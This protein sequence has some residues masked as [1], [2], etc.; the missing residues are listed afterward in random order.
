M[1]SLPVRQSHFTRGPAA[2]HLGASL[3]WLRDS[4]VGWEAVIVYTAMA[5]LF[6]RHTVAHLGSNCSCSELADSWQLTWPF[7]WFPY[8]LTHGLNPWYTHAL[9][10][11]PGFNV[12]GVTS[13]P[14]PAILFAPVTWLWGPIVA[15]NLAILAAM[16]LTAWATYQ[17][18]R[19]VS[20]DRAAALVAGAT[21]GFGTY[22][23]LQMGVGHIFMTLFV[24]P[25]L[26][27]FAALRYMDGAIGRRRVIV[28]LTV[29]LIIQLFTGQEVLVTMTLF[30]GV[31]LLLGYALGTREIRIGLRKLILPLVIGYGVTLVLSGD[32]LYWAARA[33]KYSIGIGNAWPTDL[34]SYVIPTTTTWVGGPQF[35]SVYGL[36]N[37]SAESVA[38]IGLPLIL[39]ALRWICTR[40]QRKLSR[41]LAAASVLS[42]LWTLGPALHVAGK[43]TMWLP[44]RLI[45]GLPVI[46]Q[47]L[48]S[49]TAVYTE[50]LAA[51]ML[52]LWLADRRRRPWLKW[53]AALVAALC[54]FPNFVDV[55]AA[56]DSPRGI[57]SFFATDM[58]RSYI[59]RGAT[60]LPISWGYWSPSL[61]WQADDA[62]YYR[63][64]SGYFTLTP[65]PGW[66]NTGVIADLWNNTPNPAD[67]PALRSLL[68]ARHV[69]DVVVLPG[70]MA[71]WAGVL[72][73]A[74]LSHPISVGG[75]YLYRGQ[76]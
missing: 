66:P 49:R 30:G 11:P 73:S 71:Q 2:H 44:Y 16:V 56:Y 8:A 67:G 40:W 52:S 37:L 31:L 75:I 48:E 14:L 29:A 55:S 61:M 46:N 60:V 20:K 23:L 27:A 50:L 36:F 32:F 65:P 33:P 58:Y 5:L 64:A 34:L 53:V 74:G 76:W 62:M 63:L 3:R 12:A 68:I 15:S 54:V 45:A 9:W 22:V 6:G 25:Q 17:L 59:K 38:Y 72:S 69:D 35:A 24:G 41:F 47:I 13:F 51:V 1:T 18:C 43:A 42:V 10:N 70:D 39:I 19:Y 4:P 26:M 21:L 57:P 7:A 28:E